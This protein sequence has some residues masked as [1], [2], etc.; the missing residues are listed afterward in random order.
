MTT[1][2]IAKPTPKER[3]R[4]VALGTRLRELR[5]QAG[6]GRDIVA[7]WSGIR[8]GT[9]YRIEAGAYR[10]RASTLRRLVRVLVEADPS[11]GDADQLTA[12]LIGLAGPALAAESPYL[13][14]IERRRDRRVRRMRQ[15]VE[16]GEAYEAA[17]WETRPRPR[18]EAR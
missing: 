8:P 9:L 7:V 16:L 4:L 13:A 17:W 18:G 11:I 12:D 14:S 5:D 10:T 15:L 1:W 6:V 2:Q 3:L